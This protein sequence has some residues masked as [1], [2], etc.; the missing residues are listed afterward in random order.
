MRLKFSSPA[1]AIIVKK[2]GFFQETGGNW[3][4]IVNDHEEFAIKRDIKI[5]RQNTH[6]YE[7]IDGLKPGDRVIVSSYNSFGGKDKLIFR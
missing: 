7:V 3:I 6:F 5:G 2:G 1:D 4:Y